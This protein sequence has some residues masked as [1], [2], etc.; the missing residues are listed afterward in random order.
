[1]KNSVSPIVLFVYNRQWHTEQTIEALKKNELAVKSDLFIFSDGPEVENDEKVKNVREYIKTL[2]GFKSVTIIERDHNLGLADSI[3]SG[4]TE[5]VNKY[6]KIIVLEDDIVTVSNFLQYMNE[7]L[8]KYNKDKRIF[9]ISGYNVD[10]EVPDSKK[11]SV[12]LTYR[13]STWGWATWLDRWEVAD[14]N[15]SDWLHI[16]DSKDLLGKF[17][18]GG[19]DL[20]FVFRAFLRGTVSS[21][22]IRWYYNNFYKDLFTL[23]PVRTL[24]ENIGFDGTGIHCGRAQEAI[25][26]PVIKEKFIVDLPEDIEF[27]KEIND[28]FVSRFKHGWKDRAR[29]FLKEFFRYRIK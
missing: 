2:D 3:I 1:M 6:G 11:K 19:E 17:R 16:L 29:R 25:H 15:S 12:F 24:V 9:A 4:V 8:E 22:A 7:A 14:W 26:R 28:I 20:E 13:V 10:M 27:D 18:R 23:Y 5:I 21:W